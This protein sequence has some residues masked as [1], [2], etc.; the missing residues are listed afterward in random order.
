M[1]ARVLRR[2]MAGMLAV[3]LAGCGLSDYESL[4]RGSQE[5]I[6]RFTEESEAL[7]DPITVPTKRVP[8]K[9][10]PPDSKASAKDAGKSPTTA[11][12]D[13]GKSPTTS[14]D[15]GK[16][17]TPA[18][19]PAKDLRE[20]IIRYPFFLRLPRGIRP[21]ADLEPKF[22]LVYRYPRGASVPVLPFARTPNDTAAKP[23]ASADLLLNGPVS[24]IVEVYL[25]FGKEPQGVFVD[26][27]A[28]LLP[29]TGDMTGTVTSVEVPERKEPLSFDLREFNDA[30]SAWAVYA[31]N[32]GV[33]T[34][35]I[36]FR[37]ERGQKA[38]LGRQLEL[39][40]ATLAMGNEAS[41]VAASYALRPK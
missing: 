3:L 30:Q 12:K 25:A 5:R 11:K 16:S 13:T 40:L 38:A 2:A 37:M 31:H 15:T 20:P 26:K 39:S 32:E 28:R 23:A 7:G 21:T 14:K 1:A 18:K 24:G 8:P 6:K 22:D 34:V 9:E 10:S 4:M 36:V 19:D 33:G 35:A 27:V 17:S 41:S 29:R